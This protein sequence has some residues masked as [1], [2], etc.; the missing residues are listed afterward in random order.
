[1]NPTAPDAAPGPDGE[2]GLADLVEEVTARLK[3]GEAVNLDAFLQAHPDHA[4]ELRRL[5]PALRLLADASHSGDLSCPPDATEPDGPGAGLGELGDFRLLRELGRGGMGVVYEAEQ[6]SLRRRVALKVMPMAA[7]LDSKQLQRFK[8]EAQAA[9]HLLHQNIVAVH[10]VGCERG[11]HFYAMQLIDG[12]T[13]AALI[14]ELRRQR[15]LSTAAPPEAD[16]PPTALLSTQCSAIVPAFFRAAAN[17]GLQAAEA[18][19]HAHQMGV[20]HRDVKPANLLVDGHIHLWVTDFGLARV[21]SEANLTMTGDVV[22]T[23]RYMSPEQAA[24]RP[25]LVDQRSDVYSLGVTLYEFLTLEPA[26][27]GNDRQDLL[28]RVA[29]EEPPPPRRWN[30]AIPRD[31]ETIVLKAMAKEPAERYTTAQEL[32]DD[33]RRFLDDKPVRARR[34]TLTQRAARWARRHRPVVACAVAFLFLAV[35]GLAAST[36]LVWRAERRATAGWAEAEEAHQGEI[37]QRQRA[38]ANAEM[39]FEAAER[40]YTRVAEEWLANQP[41]LED[42]QRQFLLDALAFYERFA[43]ENGANPRVRRETG[44]AFGRVGRIRD[45]LGEPDRAEEAYRRAADHQQALADEFPGESGYRSDLAQSLIAWVDLLV[46]LN[47]FPEAEQKARRTLLLFEQLCKATPRSPQYRLGAARTHGAL[48]TIAERTGRAREAEDHYEQSLALRRGLRDEFPKDLTYQR[49][50]AVALH[51]RGLFR[52]QRGRLREAEDDLRQSL[53]LKRRL[54]AES[55]ALDHRRDQASSAVSLGALLRKAGRLPEAETLLRQA[56]P[57]LEQ[58]AREFPRVHTLPHLLARCHDELGRVLQS[59][60][61][62][63]EAERH[64]EQALAVLRKLAEE[65]PQVPLYRHDLALCHGELGNRRQAAGRLA[66][67]EL[68]VRQARDLFQKLADE[69]PREVSYRAGLGSA[70]NNLGALLADLGRPSQALPAYRAA[71]KVR[72]GLAKQFPD[73]DR[74]RHALAQTLNNMAQLLHARGD[75][76]GEVPLWVEAIGHQSAAL[77]RQPRH[78]LYRDYLS[79]LHHAHADTL[80]S[81]G[82]HAEAARAAADVPRSDPKRWQSAF[83]AA[84]L[85]ARCA[86]LAA[87]DPALPEDSRRNLAPAYAKQAHSWVEEAA[88]RAAEDSRGLNSIAW[89]LAS[90]PRPVLRD[91]RRAIELATRAVKQRPKVGA[92]WCTLGVAHYRAGQ[93]QAAVEALEKAR[94]MLAGPD[95]CVGTFALAMAYWQAGQRE[96]GLRCYDEAARDAAALSPAS[97]LVQDFRAEAAA[98]LGLPVSPPPKSPGKEISR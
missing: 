25:G 14:T 79:H 68:A 49:S 85:L 64:Y 8:N 44:R 56:V 5:Y 13:V 88:R 78:A 28:R 32:A 27:A 33:L 81:L 59:A 73:D 42:V 26:F 57:P 75:L 51:N 84:R 1:M 94:S 60:R 54:A 61:R 35:A 80:A 24:A 46:S 10:A 95:R 17:L 63:P 48:G 93:W 62:L 31:L 12:V 55:P 38:E 86:D 97:R 34:P 96:Q 98:L 18:L 7:A 66:E 77:A 76:A 21:H 70:G 83:V 22:G 39:A 50:V 37:R 6:F 89:L 53:Q 82:R 58:L 47:R 52:Q 92:F 20:L 4:A 65:V 11:V 36:L 23:L 67:A 91:P 72:R 29:T 74:H 41:G 43:A 15:G 19:E 45:A 90:D 40:M 71:L 87:K 30:P 2:A 9:A 3:A 16:T 69:F